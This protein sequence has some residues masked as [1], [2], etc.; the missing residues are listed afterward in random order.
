M[1]NQ[2]KNKKIIFIGIIFILMF[3]SKRHSLFAAMSSETFKINADVVGSGGAPGT[4]ETYKMTDTLGQPV[5]GIGSSETFKAKQGFWYMVNYSI[6]MVIDSNTVNLG[7][8]TPGTPNEGQSTIDVTTDAWG[9]YK[10]L[11]SQNH[12]LLHTDTTTTIADYS[13]SIVSPCLWTG[14]G[15][16]FTIKSGSSVEA[17]WGSN[18]NYKYAAFPTNNPTI[19]HEKPDYA[20]GADQTVVG[21]KVDAPTTQK[22]GQYSNII[23]Y[24][25]LAEL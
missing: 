8:L 1:K 9:G 25:A 3:F 10:L 20:S 24:T 5:V 12:S 18:P 4:S 2:L 23:T 14:T 19:F 7:T 21:Y 6:S 15:L 22:S 16:G 11:T 13:C 17:K